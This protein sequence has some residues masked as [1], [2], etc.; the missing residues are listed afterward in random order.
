MDWSSQR[1]RHNKEAQERKAATK[2]TQKRR[3]KVIGNLYE[4]EIEKRGIDKS[5]GICDKDK[6]DVI[7]ALIS[8]TKKPEKKNCHQ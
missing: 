2:S 1:E 8:A 4:H 6:Q 3:Q 7:D 5:G